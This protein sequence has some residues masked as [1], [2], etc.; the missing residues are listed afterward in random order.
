MAYCEVQ[1]L[2]DALNE[3]AVTRM[4][5]DESTDMEEII[6]AR[7][8]AMIAKAGE[9]VDGYLRGRY[10]LPITNIPGILKDLCVDIALYF[11]ATRKGIAESSVEANL[12]TKYKDALGYLKDVQSGK[13]DIGIVDDDGNNTPQSAVGYKSP[14]KTFT[15][16][17][18]RGF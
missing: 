15:D 6:E 7:I 12:V 1:D 3:K 14:S 10:A 13:A 17:F 18:F 11:L 9:R 2:Y 5:K 16:D 8:D 4:A